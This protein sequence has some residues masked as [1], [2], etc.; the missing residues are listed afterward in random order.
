MGILDE[1]EEFED[2]GKV[3][4]E[5]RKDRHV[6]L[7]AGFAGKKRRNALVASAKRERFASV[8]M[9]KVKLPPE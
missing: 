8:S 4:M 3:P 6:I 2:P 7:K 5:I 1:L 9:P